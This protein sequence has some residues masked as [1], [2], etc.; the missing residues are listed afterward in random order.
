[1]TDPSILA[2]DPPP[3]FYDYTLTTRQNNFL[4]VGGD[5]G[6][7]LDQYGEVGRESLDVLF[8]RS[9]Q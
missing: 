6:Q 3:H 5:E 4:A 1:M 7:L 9:R 2:Y 8:V